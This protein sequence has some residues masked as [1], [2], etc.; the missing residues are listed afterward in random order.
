MEGVAPRRGAALA[1]AQ[2]GDG[3]GR[4]PAVAVAF[5]GMVHLAVGRAVAV[6][7]HLAGDVDLVGPGVVDGL[8]A[9]RCVGAEH[10]AREPAAAV[11]GVVGLVAVPVQRVVDEA[12]GVIRGGLGTAGT[13]ERGAVRHAREPLGR[14]HGL[15]A[16]HHGLAVQRR[17]VGGVAAVR[18]RFLELAAAAFDVQHPAVRGV[19]GDG[20]DLHAVDLDADEQSLL[21]GMVEVFAGASHRAR[22]RGHLLQ[23]GGY[24]A[25]TRAFRC[26]VVVGPGQ[27][28]GVAGA[29]QLGLLHRAPAVVG[30][31]ELR[32]DVVFHARQAAQ[33]VPDVGQPTAIDVAD[34]AQARGRG[35]G[36][37]A[38]VLGQIPGAVERHEPEVAHGVR[39][40]DGVAA[41][42]GVVVRVL[43]GRSA[44]K[45]DDGVARHVADLGGDPGGRRRDANRLEVGDP[46]GSEQPAVRGGAAVGA[47]QL[48]CVAAEVRDVG[49]RMRQF[50]GRQNDALATGGVQ[51]VAGVGVVFG[52]RSGPEQVQLVESGPFMCTPPEWRIRLTPIPLP[53][54][55]PETG[56]GLRMCQIETG[57]E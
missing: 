23:A 34:L 55:R 36:V 27:V 45:G 3:A 53:G 40:R 9:G 48:E 26:V 20:A 19:P 22:R 47:G 2:V 31:G 4:R 52:D 25:G 43:V 12:V 28:G 38:L 7:V 18:E 1:R 35:E 42:V 44:R 46:V 8:L 5:V 54:S 39:L 14:A 17:Q 24:V 10:Q 50:A 15:E 33:V 30:E 56:P 16:V 11:V 13:A 21:R 6:P 29:G 37:V 51:V 57:L 32:S 49:I 41:G